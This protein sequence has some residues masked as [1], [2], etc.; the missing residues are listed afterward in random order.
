MFLIFS[1]TNL[2]QLSNGRNCI[3]EIVSIESTWMQWK[4]LV[5]SSGATFDD[6]LT[7]FLL[8]SFILKLLN[9]IKKYK[10]IR[11]EC[12]VDENWY[13]KSFAVLL[14]IRLKFKKINIVFFSHKKQQQRVSKD[15]LELFETIWNRSIASV[16]SNNLTP[17]HLRAPSGLKFWIEKSY[18][19]KR[20]KVEKVNLTF[21]GVIRKKLR[22]WKFLLREKE[23]K[24]INF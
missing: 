9:T 1:G 11:K 4:E 5:L 10:A 20:V 3:G 8:S 21:L 15:Y 24:A 14:S 6:Y 7:N 18:G 13:W 12:E 23:M 19:K 22:S 17:N 16:S 2:Q